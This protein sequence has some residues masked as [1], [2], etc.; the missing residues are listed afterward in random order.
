MSN[1][2]FEKELQKCENLDDLFE[3][4]KKEHA[5]EEHYEK[6][7]YIKSIPPQPQ[8]PGIEKE[9]FNRDGYINKDKYD[10]STKILFILKEANIYSTKYRDTSEEA[11]P[12]EREQISWY[13]EYINKEDAKDNRSNQ[14]EKMG[15][16]AFYLQNKNH[17]NAKTP[18][19]IEYKNALE[20]CAF[21]NMNKRGGKESVTKKY[22]AYVNKYLK[23][24]IK[25]IEL[26]DPDYIIILGSNDETIKNAIKDTFKHKKVI[27]MLHTA[28]HMS[29]INRHDRIHGSNKNVDLYMRIFFE[30]VK[31]TE[32]QY[33]TKE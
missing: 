21:M 15:R 32:E 29:G 19:E 26:I 14:R 11:I 13:Q 31:Q 30:E 23:Y 2:L 3:L 24:I 25:Q 12:S 33:K 6:T 8:I 10:N 18:T 22:F 1:I 7:T 4:W 9:S 17:N 28:N 16:M 27:E 5:N 20:S